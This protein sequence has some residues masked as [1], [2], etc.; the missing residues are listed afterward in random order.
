MVRRKANRAGVFGEVVEPQG[1]RFLDEGPEDAAA[2]REI[3][4]RSLCF[5]VDA[6]DHEALQYLTARVDDA[7]RGVL[8]TG[9]LG[10]GLHDLLENCVERELGRQRNAG[11][12]KSAKAVRLGHKRIISSSP[13]RGASFPMAGH[14]RRGILG[15]APACPAQELFWRS[16]AAQAPGP[17]PRTPHKGAR[18]CPRAA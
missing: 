14:A 16:R 2:S 6:G 18:H 5:L 7:Q 9:Q 11:V 10:S 15:L 3:A 17:P 8:S 1:P 12:E 4:D 13:Q